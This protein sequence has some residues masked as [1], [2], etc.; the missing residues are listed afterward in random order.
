M[1]Q[2]KRR[3]DLDSALT[4]FKSIIPVDHK[5]SFIDLTFT[6][7]ILNYFKN[8]NKYPKTDNEFFLKFYRIVKEISMD[9][10]EFISFT[11]L[12]DEYNEVKGDDYNLKNI[13]YLCLYS[14]REMNEKF[15]DIFEKYKKDNKDFREWDDKNKNKK[16]FEIPMHK[17][18]KRYKELSYKNNILNKTR[19]TDYDKLLDYICNKKVKVKRKKKFYSNKNIDIRKSNSPNHDN[20][21][22]KEISQ[23]EEPQ[24]SGFPNIN[25]NINIKE[26]KDK[27]IFVNNINAVFLK[28]NN[29]DSKAND[30]PP[31]KYEDY[32]MNFFD[33]FNF[34]SYL[35][36]MENNLFEDKMDYLFDKYYTDFFG[37]EDGEKDFPC[38]LK[39]NFDD[40]I[41]EKL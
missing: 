33:P 20:I 32:N 14:K 15:S 7:I 39:P 22:K 16:K 19:V 28:D 38:I 37:Y 23:K 24:N 26:E 13:F 35:F 9:I 34:Q 8:K 30:I 3:C 21:I 29:N 5:K 25:T 41:F 2:K 1:L 18:N 36:G 10:N 27:Y 6:N 17:F 12:F 11:L 4:S 31:L 40:S